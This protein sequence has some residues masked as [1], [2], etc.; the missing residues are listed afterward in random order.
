MAEFSQ[1]KVNSAIILKDG[2]RFAEGAWDGESDSSKDENAAE[3]VDR[4]CAAEALAV[5]L[6]LLLKCFP[7]ACNC[8]ESYREREKALG[9]RFKDRDCAYCDNE[10]E[11]KQADAALALWRAATVKDSL[12]AQPD[13][14]DDER[15]GVTVPL[16]FDC[17][18]VGHST[19]ATRC[20]GCPRAATV[21]DHSTVQPGEKEGL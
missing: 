9:H 15:P 3:I 8:H 19:D 17:P 6:G 7:A 10:A 5:A 16:C 1:G 20:E 21:E 12:T 14:E 4:L 18:P 11:I 2:K 13:I